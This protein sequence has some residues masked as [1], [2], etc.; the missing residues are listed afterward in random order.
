MKL[1]QLYRQIVKFGIE[2]DPRKKKDFKSFQDTAILYGNPQVQVRKILIGI[3]IESAELLL[4]D[5]IRSLG[6]LDLGISHH[7][8][9]KAWA[10]FYEVMQL[11]V[12]LLVQAGI[13]RKV[14][15]ALLEERKREVERR[16]SA[17][18]HLRSVDT[19]RVLDLPFMC[20]HTPADNHAASFIQGLMIKEKPKTVQDMLKR[21][22]VK[23]GFPCN[24]HS[25]RRG[26]A[27]HLH[28]RGLSTLSIMH[29]GRWSSLEMVARYC[30]SIT[31]DDCLEHYKQAIDH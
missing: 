12:D 30:R 18:N 2:R 13:S 21:M 16:V 31:F 8:E 27:C 1:S 11:Q 10:I 28:K 3:D 5:R 14:A 4:A 24:A 9:G 15:Q 6:G 22:S 23:V 29:L 7:P 17:Q 19:A 25:F 20:V 26:F